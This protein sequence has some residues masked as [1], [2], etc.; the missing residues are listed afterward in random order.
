M[1]AVARLTQAQ[2][3]LM[4]R[5]VRLFAEIITLDE[6]D[7]SNASR[8]PVSMPTYYNVRNQESVKIPTLNLLVDGFGRVLEEAETSDERRQ[9]AQRV[10]H[11]MRD[12]ASHA[13][14]GI[15][16][17]LKSCEMSWERI[18]HDE[19]RRRDASNDSTIGRFGKELEKITRGKLIVERMKEL[20]LTLRDVGDHFHIEHQ[21]VNQWRTHGVSEKLFQRIAPELGLDEQGARTETSPQWIDALMEARRLEREKCQQHKEHNKDIANA[22][23]KLYAIRGHSP[24]SHGLNISNTDN[25]LRHIAH[26]LGFSDA[27]AMYAEAA[28]LEHF[29][30][31]QLGGKIKELGAANRILRTYWNITTENFVE[32]VPQQYRFAKNTINALENPNHPFG[33][34]KMRYRKGEVQHMPSVKSLCQF[35]AG[36]YHVDAQQPPEKQLFQSCETLQFLHWAVE[37]D[38][39]L[40]TATYRLKIRMERAMDEVIARTREVAAQLATPEEYHPIGIFHPN[41][42]VLR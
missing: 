42:V 26:D 33:K 12:I 27:E 15:S 18:L 40:L 20:N 13:R 38:D 1:I 14:G 34:V 8:I 31:T 41:A 2:R 21:A 5:A 7:F 22:A 17:Q 16:R 10:I 25:A 29:D 24:K 39:P 6:Q 35:L 19:E 9:L 36:I 23:R 4:A 32:R 30:S 28:R 3:P 11:C 37:R